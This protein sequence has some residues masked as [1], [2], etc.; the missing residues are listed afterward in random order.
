ML[1]ALI[2]GCHSLT[3]SARQTVLSMQSRNAPS[4]CVN[5]RRILSLPR[6]LRKRVNTDILKFCSYH[7]HATGSWGKWRTRR[8]PHRR[9]RLLTCAARGE[10][11]WGCTLSLV[12]CSRAYAQPPQLSASRHLAPLS[13]S[14]STAL[15]TSLVCRQGVTPKTR[16]MDTACLISSIV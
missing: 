14:P 10:N 1:K 8:P 9:I 3:E 2:L 16:R 7:G 6:G 5:S 15:L 11:I 13:Q 12:P 4:G